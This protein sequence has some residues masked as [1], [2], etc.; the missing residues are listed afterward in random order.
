M[1]IAIDK[2]ICTFNIYISIY[3]YIRMYVVVALHLLEAYP[4]SLVELLIILNP[5]RQKLLSAERIEKWT[6]EF[7]S[8]EKNEHIC[9]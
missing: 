6:A 2:I 9:Y 5:I 8:A 1:Y 7:I 3:L 4:L